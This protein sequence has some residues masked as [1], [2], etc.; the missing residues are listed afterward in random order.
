M[1][2]INTVRF[3]VHVWFLEMNRSW[4][5]SPSIP[6]SSTNSTCVK[7]NRCISGR[8]KY[9]TC[10]Q[11]HS[12]QPCTWV[13]DS[14]LWPI[15]GLRRN[16]LQDQFVHLI[17]EFLRHGT[18]AMADINFLLWVVCFLLRSLSLR[19][20][21]LNKHCSLLLLYR[22]AAFPCICIW[23]QHARRRWG[24]FLECNIRQCHG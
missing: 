2:W 17:F 8:W 18:L 10:S 19:M 13:A 11:Q 12:H 9:Q 4:L 7:Y 16:L 23:I 20:A 24:L 22:Q 1:K 21:K 5:T 15:W 14:W 6:I 3:L